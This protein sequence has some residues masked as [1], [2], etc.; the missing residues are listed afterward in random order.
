MSNHQSDKETTN[1]L[2]YNNTLSA[3]EIRKDNTISSHSTFKLDIRSST[4]IIPFG[5]LGSLL[6]ST[7]II[8][9]GILGSLL[10]VAK[11]VNTH[12]IGDHLIMNA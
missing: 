3:K 11:I 12:R 6:W 5:I 10:W 9:F 2:R 1:L 4:G 7:G 8:P